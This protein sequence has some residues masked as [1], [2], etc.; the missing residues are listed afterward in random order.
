MKRMLVLL[1]VSGF[2]VQTAIAGVCDTAQA[3]QQK[4]DPV[5][6]PTSRA[7]LNRLLDE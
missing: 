4:P 5:S 7:A 2:V 1:L 6:D 3:K